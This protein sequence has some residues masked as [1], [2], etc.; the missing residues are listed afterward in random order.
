[1]PF[2]KVQFLPAYFYKVFIKK[3]KQPEA[4]AKSQGPQ[5]FK[6]DPKTGKKVPVPPEA[7]QKED[8][9]DTISVK[10]KKLQTEMME[11]EQDYKES[12][13]VKI[14]K[15]HKLIG[16][17]SKFGGYLDRYNARRN[18]Y[19]DRLTALKDKNQQLK[20]FDEL[21]HLANSYDTTL[22]HS[23][24]FMDAEE[25]HLTKL[26]LRYA[27]QHYVYNEGLISVDLTK[28]MSL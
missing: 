5:K 15:L 7:P 21:E 24:L 11:A 12:E 14:P 17:Q 19:V 4:P 10:T 9:K 8:P 25:S 16:K 28:T 18:R 20:R 13:K 2:K 1:V 23:H 26:D 22:Q 3:K 27:N 6:I